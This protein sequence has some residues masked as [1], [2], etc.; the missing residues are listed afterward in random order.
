MYNANLLIVR[1][2]LSEVQP[3]G[4]KFVEF[5]GNH[6]AVIDLAYRLIKESTYYRQEQAKRQ[7]YFAAGSDKEFYRCI[8]AKRSNI[9]L[10]ARSILMFVDI[11]EKFG[12]ICI[13][14]DEVSATFKVSPRIKRWSQKNWFMRILNPIKPQ[15]LLS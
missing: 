1:I 13:S 5:R 7:V 10:D 3:G 8:M 6:K 2:S 14:V 11:L 12:F 4:E 9:V 15:K